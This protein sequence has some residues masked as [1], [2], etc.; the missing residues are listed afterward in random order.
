VFLIRRLDE[1]FEGLT[2]EAVQNIFPDR[3]TSFA[4][5]MGESDVVLIQQLGENVG[6]RDLE[7]TAQLIE[8]TLRENGESMVVVGIGTVAA[9]LRDLA[10]SYKEAQVAIE[11]GKVFD[12]EKYVVSYE[13]LG[14]RPS[15]LSAADHPV[16]DV[17]AG[18]LQE[19]PHRLAR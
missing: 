19:E 1:H 3:Q 17:P 13:N 16:R 4:L 8:E 14:N 5:S 11:V 6:T 12:T 18:G 10:K 15:D 2:V 7:K 9:H